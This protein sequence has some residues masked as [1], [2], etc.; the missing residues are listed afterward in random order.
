LKRIGGDLGIDPKSIVDFELNVIDT[1]PPAVIG[2]H[3]EFLSSPRLDNLA[4]S[5]V[6]VDAIL[7]APVGDNGEVNMIFLFDHEEVGSQSAQGADSNLAVEATTRIFESLSSKKFS[8]SDYYCAIRQ[9]FLI[10]ADMA[11]ALH[12]N[13]QEKHQASHAPRVHKG[14][15]LKTN[16]NQRYMTD[17]IGATVIRAIAEKA[18]GGPVPIQD[19]MVK[20]DSACGST[21]GPMMAAK[22]GMKTADIGAPMLG[23]HSIRETCGVIDLVHYLSLFVSFFKNY[24][25]LPGEL[26]TE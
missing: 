3:K 16:A 1:Q 5:L 9:S 10:S 15:V 12:P 19:F 8:Q 20:N 17:V 23:M 7:D 24:S 26:F 2:L 11:H 18:D 25:R 14:I 22:A 21:I 4:S 13:Y 6:A